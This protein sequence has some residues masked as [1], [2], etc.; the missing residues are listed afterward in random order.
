[1]NPTAMGGGPARVLV[2]DDLEASR[3]IACSWL[4]RSGHTVVPR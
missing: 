3:F 2:V 1:M 4:R